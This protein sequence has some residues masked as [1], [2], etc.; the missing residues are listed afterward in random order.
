M[1]NGKDSSILTLS[2]IIG[3]GSLIAG[4][5]GWPDVTAGETITD[6]ENTI[7][8]GFYAFAIPSVWTVAGYA[9][10]IL[11]SGLACD[12]LYG[13]DFSADP[14]YNYVTDAGALASACWNDNNLYYLVYPPGTAGKKPRFDELPGAAD[15]APDQSRTTPWGGVTIQDLIFGSLRSY[16][17]N[18]NQVSA[19]LIRFL[20]ENHR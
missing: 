17:V 12:A 6:L 15:L 13:P 14:I 10:F 4:N 5:G 11:A 3:N 7:L 19:W 2:T 18:G 8:N 9:P 1:F 20:R 16:E